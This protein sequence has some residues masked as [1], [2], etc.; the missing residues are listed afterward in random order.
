MGKPSITDS[1]AQLLEDDRTCFDIRF[2]SNTLGTILTEDP[3]CIDEDSTLMDVTNLLKKGRTGCVIVVNKNEQISGIFSERDMVLK[4]IGE[5]S[6]FSKAH[7][8]DY[9]TKNPICA[10][11]L[12]TIAHGLSIMSEGGFRH[13]PVVD[14]SK[15]PVGIV[16]VKDFVDLIVEKIVNASIDSL[17]L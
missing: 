5:V 11:P 6:D 14:D 12:T 3:I 8:K 13:I 16:S 2:F 10:T 1:I 15:M 9:M 17:D 7:V 4:V